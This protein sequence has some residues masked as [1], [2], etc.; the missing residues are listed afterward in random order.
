MMPRVMVAA[1]QPAPAVTTTQLMTTPK[2]S[3]TP[4]STARTKDVNITDDALMRALTQLDA[5]SA[6]APRSRAVTPHAHVSTAQL[7]ALG[8]RLQSEFAALQV[9]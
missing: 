7:D 8:K 2:P 6:R 9:M 3:N 1:P 4:A 5:S